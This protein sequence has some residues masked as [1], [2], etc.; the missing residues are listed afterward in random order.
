MTGAVWLDV[1]WFWTNCPHLKATLAWHRFCIRSVKSARSA[2][3]EG[4]NRLGRHSAPWSQPC[5]P[6]LFIFH[7]VFA[8]HK[9]ITYFELDRAQSVQSACI[10]NVRGCV[11]QLLFKRSMTQAFLLRTV[12]DFLHT[13]PFINACRASRFWFLE[14]LRWPKGKHRL[15]PG[16]GLG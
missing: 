14:S 8:G 4:E 9:T 12:V 2:K 16:K 1:A 3:S 5:F 6:I 13:F 11:W 15:K 10:L 7:C